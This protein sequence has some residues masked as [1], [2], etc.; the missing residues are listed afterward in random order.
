MIPK[1]SIIF[2]LSGKISWP[3]PESVLLFSEAGNNTE[4]KNACL[5]TIG[6]FTAEMTLKPGTFCSLNLNL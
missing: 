4:V 6:E 2:A 5:R 3:D 1:K